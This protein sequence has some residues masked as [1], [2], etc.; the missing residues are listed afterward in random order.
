M[1]FITQTLNYYNDHKEQLIVAYLAIQTVA[2]SVHD[3]LEA[4]KDKKGL[5][6]IVSTIFSVIGYLG[7]GKRA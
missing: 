4:N 2:K 1:N 6:K 5:D 3:G 7:L